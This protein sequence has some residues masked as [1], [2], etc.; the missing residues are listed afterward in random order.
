[1]PQQISVPKVSTVIIYCIGS[2]GAVE[3]AFLLEKI[4]K[5]D[6]ITGN[7]TDNIGTSR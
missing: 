4:F 6:P 3:G 7:L 1:M 2:L 5:I